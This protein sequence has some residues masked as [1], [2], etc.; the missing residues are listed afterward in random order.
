MTTKLHHFLISGSYDNDKVI[1]AHEL[2]EPI[3]QVMM[4]QAEP[5]MM[6]HYPTSAFLHPQHA[7]LRDVWMEMS[8]DERRALPPRLCM[9]LAVLF[10]RADPYPLDDLASSSQR[11][12]SPT[13]PR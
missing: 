11:G 12:S 8:E 4:E 3:R 13:N 10:V 2:M 6:M 7:A 9:A 5:V 1:P